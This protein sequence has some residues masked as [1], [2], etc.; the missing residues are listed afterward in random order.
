MFVRGE[1]RALRRE[2]RDARDERRGVRGRRGVSLLEVLVSIFVVMVGIVGVASLLPLGHHETSQA[3]QNERAT[4]IGQAGMREFIIRGYD[5]AL[6]DT[7]TNVRF[8]SK[9]DPNYAWRPRAVTI[10]PVANKEY[11]LDI[12]VLYQYDTTKADDHEDNLP[13]MT[14][15]RGVKKNQSLMWK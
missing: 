12:D 8:V 15:K 4:A 3:L 11:M 9:D 7:T 5:P 14:F 13:V 1:R 10:G 2:G 6:F